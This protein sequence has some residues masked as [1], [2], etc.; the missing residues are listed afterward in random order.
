MRTRYK[1]LRP[2]EG[3]R[4]Y[5]E[6]EIREGEKSDLQHLVPKVLEELGPSSGEKQ[7]GQAPRNKQRPPLPNK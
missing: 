3:D 4:H 1:V 7:Q 6:G 5:K 2:H